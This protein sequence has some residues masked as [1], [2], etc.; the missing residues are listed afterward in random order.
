MLPAILVLT[1][2]TTVALVASVAAVSVAWV[3][4]HNVPTKKRVEKEFVPF[5]EVAP[6][7]QDEFYVAESDEEKKVEPEKESTPL[8]SVDEVK[9]EEPPPQP[10]RS[11]V[12]TPPPSVLSRTASYAVQGKRAIMADAQVIAPMS[13]NCVVC[14]VF[15]G[16]GGNKVSAFAAKT[17]SKLVKGEGDLSDILRKAEEKCLAM[18]TRSRWQDATTAVLAK[19]DWS[20]NRRR[21]DVAWIGDSRCVVGRRD[22]TAVSLTRDH[23]AGEKGE[24]RRI[25]L[26]GGR[27]ARSDSEARSGS[28]RKLL[29]KVVGPEA[30]FKTNR[31]NPKRVYPGGIT[32]TRAIGA[33]PLKNAKPQLVIAE[34]ESRS[35]RLDDDDVFALL[36]SD[37]LFESLD[38]QQ[39]VD[40]VRDALAEKLP[41]MNKAAALASVVEA[42]VWNSQSQGSTDNTTV[43]LVDLNIS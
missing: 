6:G 13:E 15:D 17:V 10:P 33:L 31:A 34:P 43:I 14:G 29:S 25:K 1:H 3:I 27:V 36:A 42:L 16:C 9:K 24:E 39:A 7:G 12:V 41:K 28:S 11:A 35:K 19:V 40:F 30:V 37:G 5:D 21:L 38:N 20:T 23:N 22:G 8:P 4:V 32:L 26:A 18:A 2:S